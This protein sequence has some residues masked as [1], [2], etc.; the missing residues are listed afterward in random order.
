[1]QFKVILH[2]WPFVCHKGSFLCFGRL[3]VT[4][5]PFFRLVITKG[6]P[7]GLAVVFVT[8]GPS[9][10]MAF[11]LTIVFITNGPPFGLAFGLSVVFA[12][13]V[14]LLIPLVT[15]TIVKP[16]TKPKGRP[17]EKK[18]TL[19]TTGQTKGGTLCDENDGQTKGGTLCDKKEGQMGDL[20]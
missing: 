4:K 6:P 19:T 5:G 8:K 13:L 17:F 7:F 9:L 18:P 3:F 10:G 14:W 20:L 16:N 15:K 2:C 12:P 11:G 1:M